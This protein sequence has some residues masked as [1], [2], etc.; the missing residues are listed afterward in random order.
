MF[1]LEKYSG[2]KS[3]E[4][5]GAVFRSINRGKEENHPNGKKLCA[6]GF[7]T[8]PGHT[9]YLNDVEASYNKC[10]YNGTFLTETAAYHHKGEGTFYS[11]EYFVMLEWGGSI[12]SPDVKTNS[13]KTN[14]TT[15]IKNTV[16]GWVNDSRIISEKESFL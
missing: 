5:Y 1:E 15:A 14:N 7:E 8:N 3:L 9:Q 12:L 2:A 11:N 6:V 13:K 4:I 16:S 10:G